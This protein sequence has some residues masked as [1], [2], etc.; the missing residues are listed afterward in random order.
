MENETLSS[1]IKLRDP[2]L[3]LP[4]LITSDNTRKLEY[5]RYRSD[6]FGDSKFAT[7]GITNSKRRNLRTTKPTVNAETLRL[8]WVTTFVS[9]IRQIK[10]V[11]GTYLT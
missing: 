11:M 10:D 1:R 3:D 5:N 4:T 9:R 8:P 2:P 7:P 6:F